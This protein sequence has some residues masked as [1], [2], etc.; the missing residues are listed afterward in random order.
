MTKTRQQVEYF[1]VAVR[2]NYETIWRM[3]SKHD[4][5]A[6]AQADLD[7][8]RG[9]TGSFNYDNA[10]LRVISRAEAKKEFGPKWEYIAIGTPPKVRATRARKTPDTKTS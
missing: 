8:R 5:E 10:E 3:V 1:C 7:E 6:A 4:T 9:Y 2:R